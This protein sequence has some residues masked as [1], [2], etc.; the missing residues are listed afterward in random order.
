MCD[1]IINWIEFCCVAHIDTAGS[2]ST[3]RKLLG[4]GL[5]VH[6]GARDRHTHCQVFKDAYPGPCVFTPSDFPELDFALLLYHTSS[7]A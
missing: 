1:G 7:C 3:A 6:T 5:S 4:F 2:P